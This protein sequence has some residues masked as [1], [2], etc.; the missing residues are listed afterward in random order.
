M[1]KTGIA[2]AVI[3][4][5]FTASVTCFSLSGCSSQLIATPAGQ[6]YASDNL[7]AKD[8]K[9]SIVIACQGRNWQVL[10]ANNHSVTARYRKPG[11]SVTVQIDFNSTSYTINWKESSGE[12]E[13][14]GDTIN[15]HYNRW[16]NNLKVDI[17]RQLQSVKMQKLYAD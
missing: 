16:V 17:D 11:M 3:I 2:S 14:K 4:A 8:V 7:T 9:N 6:I 15:R 5:L 10:D 13:R 12:M 1:K